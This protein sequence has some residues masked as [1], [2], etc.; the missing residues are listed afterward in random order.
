MMHFGELWFRLIWCEY[1]SQLVVPSHTMRAGPSSKKVGKTKKPSLCRAAAALDFPAET[2]DIRVITSLEAFHGLI[3]NLVR[4][5][6]RLFA[7]KGYLI[8]DIIQHGPD[9]LYQVGVRACNV[10]EYGLV[11]K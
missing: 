7:L 4:A 10:H 6:E 5:G 11:G 3:A 1:A 2:R 8:R 9:Y